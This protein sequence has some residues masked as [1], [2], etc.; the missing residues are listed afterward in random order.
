MR[1]RDPT[2]RV[3]QRIA[4]LAGLQVS[5][6]RK[7]ISEVGC[8]YWRRMLIPSVAPNRSEPLPEN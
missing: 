5:E 1:A 8:G 6:A 2:D 7:G 4:H 3:L